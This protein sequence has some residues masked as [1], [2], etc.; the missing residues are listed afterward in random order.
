[1]KNETIKS[2]IEL[3]FQN[4]G[5]EI[6][7]KQSNQLTIFTQMLYKYNNSHDL[8]RITNIDDVI[9]KHFIDSLFILNLIA[10]PQSLIDIG[11]GPGFPGIPIK[12]CNPDINI[13]L[14]EPRYKRVEFMDM[15]I[16]ELELK[17]I[18][19]YPHLVTER[20]FF[21]AEGVITRAL[22]KADDTLSRV[23]HFLPYGG[24]VILL[25]GPGA[26]EDLKLLSKENKMHY[27]LLNNIEYTLPNTNHERVLLEFKKETNFIKKLYYIPTDHLKTTSQ[28]LKI[29]TSNENKQYKD[30]KKLTSS[31]GIKK[32]NKILISGKKII[33]ELLQKN[34]KDY[35]LVLFDEYREDSYDLINYIDYLISK[36]KVTILK[37]SLFN[38][39]D[40]FNTKSPLLIMDIPTIPLWDN[41][42]E[43]GCNLI[44][45]FQDPANVG[46]VIRSAVAFNIKKIIILKESANPFHPKSIRASVGTVFQAP[47]YYGPS[48]K[49]LRTENPVIALDMAGTNI[50]NYTFPQKY[51]LLAGIEGPGLPA[52]YTHNTIAIPLQNNVD[53]L[54]AAVSVSIALY[55][56]QN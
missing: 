54:N 31:D 38:E 19:I 3:Y 22:E 56:I 48:L 2:K 49:K 1:M 46:S 14:A 42:L 50:K 17:K 47:L 43:D 34:Q 6:S 13:T 51:L 7:V 39:L 30:L 15:V 21:N 5:I 45:P 53:S 27:S 44:I 25:K 20:S 16:K 41:S 23:N 9:I 33:S 37:K 28:S 8:T 4:S 26:N 10:L 40:I 29:I 32:Q 52:D 55:E 12:I 24:T 35:E 36:K 11:T 18:D